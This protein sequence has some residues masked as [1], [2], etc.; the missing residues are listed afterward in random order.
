MIRTENHFLELVEAIF[1]LL[2]PYFILEN[3]FS[4]SDK[5]YFS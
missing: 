1:Q 5:N 4:E 2:A 3:H